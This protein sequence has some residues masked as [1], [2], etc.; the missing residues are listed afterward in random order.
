[1]KGTSAV[2][3]LALTTMLGAHAIAQSDQDLTGS[4][5][6]GFLQR[7]VALPPQGEITIVDAFR[8]AL[9]STSLPGGIILP[10][11]DSHEDTKYQLNPSSVSLRDVLNAITSADP[12]YK[13]TFERGVVNLVPK[14][15]QA[16]LLASRVEKFE[17]KKANLD[18]AVSE[19]LQLPE[20]KQRRAELNIDGPWQ[21]ISLLSS[22]KRP[23]TG[24]DENQEGFDVSCEDIT[25]RQA[26]NA[27]VRAHGRG[28]W[29]YYERHCN[30]KDYVGMDFIVR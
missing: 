9:G 29:R 3:C 12:S 23:G 6:A 17:L 11:A 18:L 27:I 13:W 25:L 4:R 26:L 14:E 24:P 16:P 5:R 7:R 2:V 28:V 19:L 8:G 15:D 10:A 30:G 20:V 22:L 1:M 21:N